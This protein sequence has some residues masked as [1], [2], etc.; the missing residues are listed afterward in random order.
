VTKI[1][2]MLAFFPAEARAHQIR[3]VELAIE[4]QGAD[5]RD[6]C[7]IRVGA[8][9]NGRGETERAREVYGWGTWIR[10]KIDGVRVRDSSVELSPTGPDRRAPLIPFKIS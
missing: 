2:M 3:P 5:E 6:R 4:T 10:T 1:P 8:D 7:G 9:R